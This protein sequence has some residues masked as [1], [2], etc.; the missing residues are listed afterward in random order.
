MS[1]RWQLEI[2]ETVFDFVNQ[3]AD[4]VDNKKARARQRSTQTAD[5]SSSGL[6]GVTSST[7]NLLNIGNVGVSNS[8][9]GGNLSDNMTVD[10][11]A[12]D[13]IVEGDV[14]KL[15]GPFLQTWQRKHLRLFPNRIE[16]YNKSRDGLI[17]KKGVDV[18]VAY[19]LSLANFFLYVNVFQFSVCSYI[20]NAF[21]A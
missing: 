10:G 13:C 3:E 19:V 7:G 11:V 9:S 6:S 12:S 4:K 17:L 5:V 18:S 1:E 16:I 21:L 20:Y 14:L 2:A 15:G 8:G